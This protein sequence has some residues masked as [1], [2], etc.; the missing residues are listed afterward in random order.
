MWLVPFLISSQVILSF[1]APTDNSSFRSKSGVSLNG[2]KKVHGEGEKCPTEMVH[3]CRCRS[4]S[5]GLDI[6]C[7]NVNSDQLN[8]RLTNSSYQM[9]F[10]DFIFYFRLMLAFWR[11]RSIWYVTLRFVIATFQGL[12][13]ICSWE[14]KSSI[15][16]SMIAVSTQN[17]DFSP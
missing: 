14:W 17:W 16:I 15:F 13:T 5:E 6:T 7:E 12:M 11:K 10:H 8:V 1:S 2:R 9:A 3:Y 4:K